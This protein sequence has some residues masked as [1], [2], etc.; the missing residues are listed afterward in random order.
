MYTMQS[1]KVPRKVCES[2]DR[3]NIIFLWEQ[4]EVK[5]KDHLVKWRKVCTPKIY[6]GLG[7]RACEVNNQA[8]IV[9][10][11]WKITNAKDPLGSKL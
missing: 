7:L 3:N 9:K 4:M 2:I 1:F 5:W 8:T 10:L 11:G 6:G